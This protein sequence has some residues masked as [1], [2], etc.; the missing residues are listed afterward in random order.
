MLAE[1]AQKCKIIGQQKTVISEFKFFSPLRLG[2][3]H[4]G[5]VA[6]IFL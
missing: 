6:K 3:Q 1:G 4:S 5:K 2:C